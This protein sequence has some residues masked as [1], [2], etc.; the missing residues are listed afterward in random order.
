MNQQEGG[1][2]PRWPAGGKGG[3]LF[4]L[5]LLV[6]SKVV[7]FG[8]AGPIAGL[9]GKNPR[10]VYDGSPAAFLVL[11]IAA[12]L[13]VALVFALGMRRIGRMSLRQAGWH[14]FRA[15]DVALGLAGLVVCL[16]LMLLTARLFNISNYLVR[17]VSSFS[18]QQRL[19]F[20]L[21]GAFAAFT[22]ETI[23]RG[24]LQPALQARLGPRA[25][26]VTGAVIFAVQHFRFRPLPLIN[27]T[28]FGLVYGVLRQRTGTLWASAITHA[29]VWAVMGSA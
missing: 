2:E 4:P 14:S 24:L 1:P 29:L 20:L 22:E 12:A 25:G 11:G 3:I 5:A 6:A 15:R 28:G 10:N 13:T 21:L 19:F 9:F 17:S 7:I 27:L 23:F 18:L 26:L 8:L 16:A